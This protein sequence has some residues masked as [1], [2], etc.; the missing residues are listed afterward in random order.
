MLALFNKGKLP[1]E[2]EINSLKMFKSLLER[3][4]FFTEAELAESLATFKRMKSNANAA[5]FL[6]T[7]LE[8]MIAKLEDI[9]I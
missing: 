2:M 9:V 7:H 1:V 5:E 4:D 3:G 6:K 8:H